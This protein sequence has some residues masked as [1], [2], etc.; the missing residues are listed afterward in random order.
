MFNKILNTVGVQLLISVIGLLLSIVYANTVGRDGV[1]EI[2]VIVLG[3]SIITMVNTL[4][5]SS[6]II[7]LGSRV[8]VFSI[9]FLS[10]S[11][12]VFFSIIIGFV[13]FYFN[14]IPPEY[15]IHIALIAFFESLT[16]INNQI[17]LSR[18][19]IKR[20]NSIKLTQKLIL[21]IGIVSFFLF[22]GLQET[23][24]F[25]WVYLSSII[26]VFVISF[27]SIL[28]YIDG[29]KLEN[30]KQLF[31]TKLSYGSQLQFS[32]LFSLLTNRVSY[33][34]IEKFFESTLGIFAQ[35]VQLMENNLI[36]SRSISLVQVSDIASK[37]DKDNAEKLT[38]I[39][40]KLTGGITFLMVSVMVLIPE[41]VYL[42]VFSAEFK[43]MKEVIYI[44]AP[45]I[46]VMSIS[47]ILIHYFCGIAKYY[48]STIVSFIGLVINLT[49]CFYFIPRYG[50]T[51]AG[52]SLIITNVTILSILIHQFIKTTNLNYIDLVPTKEDFNY[53]LRL[54]KLDEK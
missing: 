3:F 41:S 35:G 4:L 2:A 20:Y 12:I 25:V 26:S 15:A 53:G 40:L 46:V 18:N 36:V 50:I 11:W 5:G 43:G 32:M 14:L 49:S 1:A 31:L 13:L 7:Y 23:K 24:Y 21:L 54:L 37:D 48:Y 27:G 33:Y 45:T 39:L 47:S 51:G 6:S 44:Y 10:Y 28:K 16:T 34:L 22:L 9:L 52:I 42:F 30:T 17:I 19:H 38:L 8:S 29:Y